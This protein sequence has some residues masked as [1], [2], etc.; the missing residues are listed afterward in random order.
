MTVLASRSGSMAPAK[1]IMVNLSSS[2]KTKRRG[3]SALVTVVALRGEVDMM[4]PVCVVYGA[5]KQE[6]RR[7]ARP[8]PPSSQLSPFALPLIFS[9]PRSDTANGGIPHD[10]GLDEIGLARETPCADARL[11]RYC[12]TQRRRGAAG[13]VSS[14]GICGRGAQAEKATGFGSRGQSLPAARRRLRRKLCRVLCRQHPRHLPRD[15]AN[16]GRADL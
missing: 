12:R 4:R 7:P 9:I 5:R 14:A 13:Q 6:N 11:P 8:F 2:R 16:G 3:A 15:A 1:L 10:Q